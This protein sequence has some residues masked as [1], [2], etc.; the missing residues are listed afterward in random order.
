MCIQSN[1]KVDDTELIRLCGTNFEI[2]APHQLRVGHL[3]SHK[4]NTLNTSS[5]DVS[6]L[7]D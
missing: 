6:Q 4:P 3:M 5:S 7:I 1:S 2:F